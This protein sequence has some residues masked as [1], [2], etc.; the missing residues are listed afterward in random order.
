MTKKLKKP[1]A[2]LTVF[3]MLLS[4]LLYFPAGTFGG[5]GLGVRASAA[6]PTG[7]GSSNNPYILTTKD[8]LYWFANQANNV[9]RGICAKLGNN[10]TVN[11]SVLDSNCNLKSGPFD[12]WTPIA[13]Y[14]GIFDGNN[15]SISGIYVNNTGTS[16]QGFFESIGKSDSE[17]GYVKNLTITDSY[18]SGDEKCGGICGYVNLGTIS[19]CTFKGV[20]KG[21]EYVGG[22]AGRF[23]R[24]YDNADILNCSSYGKV[25]GTEGVGG[26]VGSVFGDPNKGYTQTIKNCENYAEVSGEQMVGGLFG[27][28]VNYK[29]NFENCHN[30][31]GVTAAT[32]RSIQTYVGGICGSAAYLT[33]S[34]CTFVN[35]NNCT[36]SGSITG[37]TY[38]GGI[39]GNA[40]SYNTYTFKNCSNSGSISGNERVGG[41]LGYIRSAEVSDCY[42]TGAVSGE[43]FV[44]GICGYSY[45][46]QTKFTRVYNTSKITGT[47]QYIGGL[48]GKTE[49]AVQYVTESYNTGEVDGTGAQGVGGIIGSC[50]RGT[51]PQS[52]KNCYN[53]GNITGA[54]YV[55][56][57][58]GV[59]GCINTSSVEYCFNTGKVTATGGS[60]YGLVSSGGEA[61]VTISN[62]YYD[63]DVNP[64]MTI[65]NSDKIAK[66]MPTSA[67][68]SGKVAYLLQAGGGNWGQRISRDVFN[69]L[70]KH[71]VLTTGST[72]SKYR[73]Y[74]A[75]YP[76][77]VDYYHNHNSSAVCAICPFNPVQPSVI[78]GVYQI[79]DSG[80]LLWFSQYVNGTLDATGTHPDAKA[81]LK[82]SFTINSDLLNK[83]NDNNTFN[84]NEWQP[85]GSNAAFTGSFDGQGHT[86]SGL[87]YD[88]DT[89]GYIG[90]FAK[91][92]SGGKVTNVGVNDSYFNGSDN[93]GG[94]AGQNAGEISNCFFFKGTVTAASG[95]NVGDICGSNSSSV[96]N[97]YYLAASETDSIDGT[98][99]MS[100]G[101]FTSG[102]VAYKLNDNP[103][104]PVWGQLIRTDA[105]P[106]QIDNANTVYYG[107]KNPVYHNH[108]AEITY[109]DDCPS[110]FGAATAPSPNTENEYEISNIDELY[111]FAKYV[112]SGNTGAHAVLMQDIEVNQRVL[113]ANGNLISDTIPYWTPIGTDSNP[114]TGSFDG[115]CFKISGLY[116]DSSADNIGLFG[117]IGS[118][119]GVSNV[120]V[121]DSYFSG[122]DYVGG[123]AGKNNGTIT[124]CFS[125]STVSAT[126]SN[127]G[128]ISGSGGT[129]NHSFYLSDNDS[130]ETKTAEQFTNGDVAYNLNSSQNTPVWG[131]VIERDLLPV[132]YN[133]VNKVYFAQDIYHNHSGELCDLCNAILPTVPDSENDVYQITKA[134]ELEWFARWVNSGNTTAKAVLKNDIKINANVIAADGTVNSGSF[135][136]IT[137]VGTQAN[138]FDGSFNGNGYT[139]G[140]LY[141]DN[142]SASNVGLFGST[143]S[144]ASITKLRIADS[145]FSAN[146]YVGSICG[147]NAGNIS[148]CCVENCVVTGK[149]AGGLCGSNSGTIKNCYNTGKVSGDKSGGICGSNSGTVS[150]CYTTTKL[151]G[152]NHGGVCGTGSCENS[153]YLKETAPDIS[154]GIG[155][156]I[157]FVDMTNDDIL[158]TWGVGSEWG[159]TSN[160][161]ND[162]RLYLPNLSAIRS[163]DTSVTYT[164]KFVLKNTNTTPIL[165]KDDL[166][167]TFETV[168]DVPDIGEVHVP[169]IASPTDLLP[170]NF[171]F[172]HND[173]PFDLGTL[174]F[175]YRSSSRLDLKISGR[176]V[177]YFNINFQTGIINVYFAEDIN[178]GTY[179][180]EIAY[181]GTG[182]PFFTGTSATCTFN[183]TPAQPTV[184]IP[185][186]SDITYGESLAASVLK[187]S[188]GNTDSTWVWLDSTIVPAVSENQQTIV[189]ANVVD[190][191]NYDYSGVYG[192]D[193]TTHLVKQNITLTIN[194]AVPSIVVTTEPSATIPGKTVTVSAAVSN[195]IN[196]T[197][198]DLPP[199]EFSYLIGNGAEQA[200]T[201][202]SFV[203]PEDTELGTVITIIA[204]TPETTKYAAGTDN[205]TTVIVTDCT[206]AG[207]VLKYDEN[208]HW[209]H[210]DNCGADLNREAHSGGTATCTN[211]AV[212]TLC[213]QKYGTV[214]ENNHT[215]IATEWSADD[216]GHWHEC[217]DCHAQVD[218]TAHTSSG[219][220]TSEL[221][222]IC[223]ICEYEINPKL[224]HVATPVITPKSGTFTGSQEIT[225]TCRTEGADIYYTTDGKTPTTSST[226]YTGAFTV[227][228]TT[229]V[230]AIAVKLGMSDSDVVS[231]KFT[232][233]S[234]GGS[235]GSGGSGGGSGRGGNSSTTSNPSIGGS[236]KSWSDIAADLAKLAIDSE[237]T[238]KLNGNT[239]VPV[240]VIKVIAERKLKVTFVVDT[241]KSWK[242]DGAEIKTPA[243][244]DLKFTKT[245]GAKSDGLRG[246]V[247]LRFTINDTNIPTD[248]EIAFKTEHAGKFANLYRYVDGK[249]VF[250][251]C[252]KL[253][254]DGKVIL[255]DVVEKGDYVVMLCEFS[256]RPGDMNNDGTMDVFDAS[257]ILKDL[258]ELEKGKNPLMAD[259]NSDGEINV[260][261]ASAILKRI[262]GLA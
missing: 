69:T 245:S 124:G 38:V 32:E 104:E 192:Y 180:I 199:V 54:N 261:D 11:S 207:K 44:G 231:A 165:Y 26:I 57:I 200:I 241:V 206:H 102:E 254:A 14:C 256:D 212:C 250:V 139:I 243:A 111:W 120:G 13:N 64:D 59:S 99:A 181:N 74:Y 31:G 113:D 153:Y 247:G 159:K 259:F 222:E 129:V 90:L 60:A 230:K 21:T 98:T 79:S 177:G 66:Q 198:N 130:G 35:V 53:T 140:G 251:T 101:S 162:R 182:N 127:I 37:K 221:A 205:Q 253:G 161:L 70:D 229:T 41:L 136:T 214:N 78:D 125:M 48:F 68:E 178:A 108:T 34:F 260:F 94:I 87:Y 16:Y 217:A 242:T 119:G 189:T 169:I 149:D 5:F 208:S 168:L 195:P 167:F 51:L 226:R 4:V 114:F 33:S 80:E 29:V 154:S 142:A 246:I 46:D 157:S 191:V 238:I 262:V 106:V 248:L 27:Y 184:N 227:S 72:S 56:G 42:N 19:N 211:K 18:I 24:A 43:Q 62:S 23:Q 49:S 203:I 110:Y 118:G 55:G 40:I 28:I 2:F 147:N 185:S 92:G 89:Q 170:S 30:Y 173:E 249:P 116:V 65:Y 86:I 233:T 196:S 163:S 137:S 150:Y 122:N 174:T 240:E 123:I 187:D 213:K 97:C 143:G 204:R 228:A 77:H 93:V 232:K 73:V 215:H 52:V 210:C 133:D 188:S 141:F 84:E 45:G 91:I 82:A 197:L 96:T 257:A 235:G 7:D 236:E 239:T 20:V 1:I 3:A 6:E 225:I 224:G 85:I 112:N 10:I 58:S 131:Q 171:S 179:K 158:T 148:E 183:I 237:V 15:Y 194:P 190:D 164:P 132:S 202:G 105:F 146:Q 63:V 75:T 36:N 160:N 219:A 220:A 8:H 50:N 117:V 201:N 244:A 152:N 71:P 128:G 193:P 258:V 107:R 156:P 9:N 17:S 126:G 25:I 39:F 115:Q 176:Y 186:A 223:T 138:P 144:N 76:E 88:N 100:E 234:Y 95:T 252:S 135:L 216:T 255:H 151:S 175:D 47:V 103:S 218:K 172:S 81:V 61:H 209:Y 155:T 67:F 109:C 166:K 121:I 22:I 83:V 12:A 134:S 145:Y